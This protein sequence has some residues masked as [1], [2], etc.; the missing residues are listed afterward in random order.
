VSNRSGVSRAR[1]AAVLLA[2]LLPACCGCGLMGSGGYQRDAVATRH[3][4]GILEP[5]R[6]PRV[7]PGYKGLAADLNRACGFEDGGKPPLVVGPVLREVPVPDVEIP[8]KVDR[9]WAGR[10]RTRPYMIG[11]VKA[12][13][14][15]IPVRVERTPSGRG[16]GSVSPVPAAK[17]EVR[18]GDTLRVTVAGHPEFKGDWRV[19]TAGRLDIPDGGAFGVG[20]FTGEAFSKSVGRVSGMKLDA[21]EREISR[22]LKPYVRKQPQVTVEILGRRGG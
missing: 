7:K 14:P 1:R 16:A 20:S 13:P 2:L 17:D 6:Q 19:T 4:D 22:Q 18:V 10:P 9:P 11:E 12:P 15:M 21:L 3:S 5:Y 8:G